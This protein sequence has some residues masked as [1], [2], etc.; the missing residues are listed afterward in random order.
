VFLSKTLRIKGDIDE[1]LQ[2][3]EEA[4]LAFQSSNEG[5]HELGPGSEPQEIA[6][7]RNLILNEVAL[8]YA[9]NQVPITAG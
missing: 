5:A 2:A 8:R 6:H 1:A 9:S 3:I 4:S 7:Q